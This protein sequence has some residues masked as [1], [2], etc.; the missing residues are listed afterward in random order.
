[1]K[2]ITTFLTAF[3]LAVPSFLNAQVVYPTQTPSS[4]ATVAPPPATKSPSTAFGLSMICPGAG[5]YYNGQ[6][7]KGFLFQAIFAGGVIAVATR[8]AQ[9]Y[10]IYGQPLP[11]QNESTYLGVGLMAGSFLI[12]MIDASAAAKHINEKA[13][14]PAITLLP[15]VFPHPGAM[16]R[17]RF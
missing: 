17:L 7:A 6:Y 5:Q 14:A 2:I 3:V 4:N 13:V 11:P 1:M 8:P 12:A 16:A 9:R 10:S 15:G